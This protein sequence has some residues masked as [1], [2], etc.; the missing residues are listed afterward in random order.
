MIDIIML[1]LSL[2][3]PHEDEIL[4]PNVHIV[5]PL[6]LAKTSKEGMIQ[7]GLPDLINKK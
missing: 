3:T 7:N 1:M 6:V 5:S 2:I 4:I